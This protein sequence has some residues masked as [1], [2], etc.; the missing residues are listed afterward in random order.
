MIDAAT[1]SEIIFWTAVAVVFY[2]YV[3]Y[4]AIVWVLAALFPHPIHTAPVTP[5]ITVLIAAHNEERYIADKIESCLHLVYPPERLN[6]IVVSDGST[7]RTAMIVESYAARY[8]D[9]V[10]LIDLPTRRGKASALNLA[11]ARASG[12]ILLLADARQQ[13]DPLVAQALA[14]NFADAEVGAV[15]GELLL[16]EAHSEAEEAPS[17]S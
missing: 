1:W 9:R 4:P 5:A 2:T 3:G 12:E 16:L 11:A 7:D 14:Q 6:L 15:S 17:P 13:F 8:P 10:M